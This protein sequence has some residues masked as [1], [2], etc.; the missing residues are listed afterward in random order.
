MKK[1]HEKPE[2]TWE[3]NTQWTLKSINGTSGASEIRA[4]GRVDLGW[5]CESHLAVLDDE[6]ALD[7]ADL[8]RKYASFV[9]T[10]SRRSLVQRP[11]SSSK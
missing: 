3:M 9:T 2:P 7:L 5:L 4:D 6:I 8:E 1:T 11:R 10:N